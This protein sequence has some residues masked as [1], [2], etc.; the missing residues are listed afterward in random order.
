M[1]RATEDWGIVGMTRHSLNE[2]EM[3]NPAA[4]RVARRAR[5][6]AFAL[7]AFALAVFLASASLAQARSLALVEAA[8]ASSAQPATPLA[9][10]P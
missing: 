9:D 8:F 3:E 2:A 4:D 1:L 10:H 5:R 6:R 7:S